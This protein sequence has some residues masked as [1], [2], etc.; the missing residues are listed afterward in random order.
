MT[1]II[2]SGIPELLTEQVLTTIVEAATEPLVVETTSSGPDI[3]AD[4]LATDVIIDLQASE[5]VATEIETFVL[6]AAEQGPPGPP[7]GISVS[8]PGKT[9]VWSAGVLTEVLLYADAA[10][11][12]LAERRVLN[13]TGNVLTSVEYRDA[14]GALLRTRQLTYSGADLVSVTET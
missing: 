11:T 4:V 3:L 7:G 1:E 13:R 8:Y 12:T 14:G 2:E 5:I 9:L 10:K 6:E